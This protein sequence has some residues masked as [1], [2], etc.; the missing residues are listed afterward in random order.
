MKKHLFYFTLLF[1]LALA[2]CENDPIAETVTLSLE[3][4]LTA[5]NTEWTGDKSGTEIKG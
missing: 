1:S 3:N 2:S 4:K 5:A